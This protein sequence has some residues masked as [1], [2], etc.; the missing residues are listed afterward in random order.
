MNRP[1]IAPLLLFAAL[2]VLAADSLNVKPGLWETTVEIDMAGL[3]LPESVTANMTPEQRAQMAAMMKQMSAQG[4]RTTTAKSCV[5]AEDLKNGEFNAARAA[6]EQDC[7][8]QAV[9]S[10]PKRREMNMT[11]S[12]QMNATGHMVLNVVDDANVNGD[13]QMKMQQSNMN[14]KFRSHWLAASCPAEERK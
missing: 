8:Y 7:K 1:R 2:P 12:G 6:Q 13:V 14:M 5:T 9:S 11:C 3:T 10:T 4:P